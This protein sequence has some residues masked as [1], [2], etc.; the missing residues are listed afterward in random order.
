MKKFLIPAFCAAAL[1]FTGC[2]SDFNENDFVRTVPAIMENIKVDGD[3][4]KGLRVIQTSKMKTEQGVEVICVRA[5]LKREGLVDFVKNSPNTISIS[6]KYT[7]FDAQGKEVPGA[8]WQT[9]SLK[10][11]NEFA[12]TSSAPAKGIT[13]VTLTIRK[14]CKAACK[15]AAT[16]PKANAKVAATCPKANAKVAANCPKAK[17]APKAVKADAKA[18]PK[19]V[20]N[21]KKVKN[22]CLCGCASGESCYCPADSACPNAG[23]NKKK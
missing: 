22:N 16:C 8:K 9:L 15:A 13:K 2:I 20:K 10:P 23:K 3:L 5:R 1:T 21:N 6:Y 14:N 12:C 19:A 11:G 18:A 7:W 4:A 17:A